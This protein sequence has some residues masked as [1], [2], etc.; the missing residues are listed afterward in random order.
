MKSVSAAKPSS[1]S[2]RSSRSPN[3]RLRAGDRCRRQCETPA[4][5]ARLENT[6]LFEALLP[7]RTGHLQYELLA[8]DKDGQE[9]RFHDPYSFP[10]VLTDLDLQLFNE[11]NHFRTYD[12]LGAASDPP[13]RRR[14][15]SVRGLGA[16]RPPRQHRGRFQPMGR[17]QPPHR[18]R[19]NSGLWEL[20]IP[21]LG[22]G[23]AYKYEIKTRNDAILL[24][25]DPQ[26]FFSEVRPKTASV[27]WDI[28]AF[29]WDDAAWMAQRASTDTL[30][31]PVSIYEAHLGCW[32]RVPE[33]NGYLSYRD[34]AHRLAE[35]VQARLYARRAAPHHRTSTGRLLGLSSD[36]LLCADESLRYAGRLPI[37]GG[38][39]SSPQHRGHRGLGA[40]PLP[41]RYAMA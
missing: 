11:G 27:V 32:I 35:Y 10:P 19:G 20:F 22:E 18:V 5:M 31:Q 9:R 39:P 29:T 8:L 23:E 4:P 33:T 1:P 16:Q 24:K 40:G 6:D 21:G 28:N 3:G 34:L 36:G 38:L 7:P 25:A 12:K 14:R 37:S 30:R 15:R 41:Q 17:A 13:R 2:G 26:A